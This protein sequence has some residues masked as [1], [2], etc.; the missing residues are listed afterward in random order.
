MNILLITVDGIHNFQVFCPT[1][2]N[3]NFKQSTKIICVITSCEK[4]EPG[5]HK[6]TALYVSHES[7]Q[8]EEEEEDPRVRRKMDN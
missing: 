1:P 2:F 8:T 4:S 5:R 7:N 6:K 3:G